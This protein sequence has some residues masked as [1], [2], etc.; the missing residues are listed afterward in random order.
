MSEFDHEAQSYDVHFSDTCVG[1]EQRRQ[2][3]QELSKDRLFNK[4][5]VLEL[6]CGTGI[7]AQTFLRRG[8]SVLAT[9][10]SEGMLIEAQKRIPKENTRELRLQELDSLNGNFTLLFSNFGGINCLDH[11]QMKS[12]LKAAADKL[13]EGGTLV[14][15][16]M[17]KRCKWDRFY[18]RS[19]GKKSEINRRDT[20]LGVEVPITGGNVTTWYY[21]PKELISLSAEY[22]SVRTQKPIGLFVPPSYLAPF[23]E[24]RKLSF[25]FL[26]FMDRLFRFPGCS[27]FSDHYY[28]SLRKK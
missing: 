26:K 20:D 28:L 21:S 3:Y 6:N 12:F 22:F 1:K 14:L 13:E 24:R 10:A 15:V 2:V 7:D 4:Q 16:V 11:V 18:L 19:K 9:D 25:G 17:G 8:N 27:N 23:F 5:R